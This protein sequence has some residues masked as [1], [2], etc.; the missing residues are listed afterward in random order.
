MFFWLWTS[1]YS[2][3]FRQVKIGGYFVNIKQAKIDVIYHVI[4]IIIMRTIKQ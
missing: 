2:V 4:I 1:G 3:N